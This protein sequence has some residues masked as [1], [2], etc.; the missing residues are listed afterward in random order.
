MKRALKYILWT[1]LALV[2]LVVMLASSLYLP[3][4]QRWAVDRLTAYI[5]EQT[6]FEVSIGSVHISPLLD[7]RLG[8][9][10]VAKP[11]TDIVDVESA[12]I[13]LDLTR[14]LTMHVGVEAIELNNGSI[15]TT[16]LIESLALE[17]SIGNLRIVADDID[18]RGKKVNVTEASLDGCELDIMLRESAEEDT[19]ESAPLDWQIDVKQFK[20]QDS[21][22]KIK[23]E[24]QSFIVDAA[25]REASL[26]GG[27]ISLSKGMYR[28]G[29]V[30][31]S[32]DSLSYDI[33]GTNPVK[34]LDVNHLAL[35]DAEL[36]LDKLSFN[37]N[38]SALNVQLKKLAFKEKSGFQLDN[39]AGNISLDATH[40]TA[41][42]LDLKTPHSTAAGNINFDWNALS[43]KQRGQLTADLQA[44]LGSQDVLWLGAAYM[45]K[46]LAKCYP[47]QPLNVNLVA[48]GNIDELM[49]QTCNVTMP[50]VI[51]VR[52][53]G[54]VQNLADS[55]HIGADLKWD[56]T[57]MDLRCLNRYLGLTDVHFPK[58]TIHADTRLRESSKLTADALLQEGKGRAHLVGDI[59]LNT[60]AYKGDARIANLQLHDFLPKDSI[61]MLTANAKFSGRGTD[62]LSP[63]T[64]LN[65][66]AD[67][68]HLGYATWNLDNI[69][70]DCRL[71][72]GKAMVEMHSQ[73]DLLSMQGCVNASITDRKLQAADFNIDL[74]HIDL[75]ALHIAKKPLAA[76][77][78]MHMDGASDF[79]QT[80]SLKARIEAIELTTADSIVHPL[81]LTLDASLT[82]ELINMK[83]LAGDLSLAVS[84]NQGLD[85]LLARIDNFTGELQREIDSL[86]IRQD[87]LRTLLPHMKVELTCG[88]KN[89]IGNILRHVTGYSFRDLS[90]HLDS[91]PENGLSGKGSMHSLNTGAILLDSIYWNLKQEPTGLALDA[92]VANGPK[93]SIVTFMSQL[94]ASLT[95]TGANTHLAFFDA[96]G[97]KSV[98][99]GLTLDLLANGFRAHFTPLNPIIAYRRFA[100]NEDNFVTLT[101]K[102]ASRRA[103]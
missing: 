78:V 58:M 7:I 53:T 100:L 90:L 62:F 103:G 27:D 18:L 49:L 20:I 74:S 57:T 4:V 94:H 13:D 86:R 66:Q 12:L 61:Y 46:D 82:P 45:P 32:A 6:G 1:L 33:P 73:N 2:L 75:Y 21:R 51:D 48:S 102:G 19:T 65:A 91:S 47:P 44:S 98:D 30:S 22:L 52:A 71:E 101:N 97:Q 80:H 15:N 36:K 77:M 5:E 25:I 9:V 76:S 29:K 24:P 85:S 16:D 40:F 23:D 34:G 38:T 10:R 95:E 41:T 14:L 87:T 64:T 55:A 88:Q 84:S 69:Q 59:D 35:R 89:P 26:D 54:S 56:I 99:F 72:K 63:K 92:R 39:L 3:P 81:D 42:G 68:T 17:G 28:V 11:P 79:K 70:A 93:N 96:N 37:Q 50:T 60:M 43:P 67:I 83:A 31:L 8:G